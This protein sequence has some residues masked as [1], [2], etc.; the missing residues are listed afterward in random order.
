MENLRGKSNFYNA[1]IFDLGGVIIDLDYQRTTAAFVKLGLENFDDIYSKAK[2]SNLFD[3]FEKGIMSEDGFRSEL[4]KHLPENTSDYEIDQ[5]WNAMLIDIPVHRVEFIKKLGQKYRIFLL[6]NTNQIHVKAFSKMADDIFGE[7]NFLE[8]FEKHYL[9]CEMGMRKP[10][11]EIFEKV[12]SENN[13]DRSKTLFIDDSKQH[14][15]GALKIR[16]HAELLNVEREERVEEKF[17]NLI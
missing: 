9:S 7:N 15:E 5:A 14:I 17:D 1:I 13:L 11:A 3:D 12:L 16:I 4:K 8:V 10:D 2:Q 6:S